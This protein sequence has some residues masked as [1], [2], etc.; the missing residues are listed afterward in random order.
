MTDSPLPGPTSEE[1]DASRCRRLFWCW[2]IGRTVVWFAVALF[3]IP[4]APLDLI[5]W[6]SW[7]NQFSWGYPKH[8]PL[9]AWLAA[10][11]VRL[12]PGDVWG[13]YLLSYLLIAVALWAAWRLGNEFFS[14]SMA[15]IAVIC[16]DGLIYLTREPAE[17]NNNIAL[18]TAWILTIFCFVRAIRSGTIVWWVALGIAVGLGLMC[19]YT[20]GILLVVLAA[21]P[22]FNREARAHLRRPGPYL[23][24]LIALAIFA[25]HVVW[26]VRHEF[27]TLQYVVQRTQSAGW[28]AHFRHPVTFAL[29]QVLLLI[30]V[31]IILLPLF[32][33]RQNH[34][35]SQCAVLDWVVWGPLIILL[36]I[37][38]VTGRQ[39]RE[40]W[41]SPLWTAVGVWLL[42]RFG[43]A[44]P[45]GLRWS[46][47][48]WAF[49]ATAMVLGCVIQ[50]VADP[51]VRG[52]PTR[53]NYPGRLLAEEVTRR[54]HTRTAV[55]LS[56]VAG[57]PW[58]AGNVCCYSSERPII[59]SSGV[60][61]DFTFEP[62]HTPWTNDADMLFRGGVLVWDAA[63]L[64]DDLPEHARLRFENAEVQSP[65]VLPYQ[66]G[67]N[68][69][70]DR[71]GIAFV[72]PKE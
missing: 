20:I 3:T 48:I 19:K 62:R 46:G 54:W 69:P 37:S 66:T 45:V 27:V 32:R 53:K 22:I 9:P 49:V 50:T 67:A 24:V 60:M 58:R 64:G 41:G 47:R 59:Y 14:P 12:S 1:T 71:V 8:P 38:S 4:N 65:I 43:S 70:P 18:D 6:L 61:G 42:A 26:L 40:I 36:T 25:P 28:T 5:E 16:L 23:A 72:W 2:L 17:F 30:P 33:F 68:V 11:F 13:V 57:E 21:F 52:R 51:Y 34:S 56:I 44:P 10:A 7:G 35:Y 15:L 31:L 39:L 63:K 55:P 29:S